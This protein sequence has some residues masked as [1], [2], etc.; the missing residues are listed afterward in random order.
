MSAP[1]A[2]TSLA[3]DETAVLHRLPNGKVSN[4]AA[5]SFTFTN[6]AG[7]AHRLQKSVNG[8]TTWTDAATTPVTAAGA[9]HVTATGLALSTAHLFRIRAENAEASTWS[10]T[11]STTTPALATVG[12]PPAMPTGFVAAGVTSYN[13]IFNWE[14]TSTNEA[15]FH[16]EV[17]RGSTVR[18]FY[19]P[20]LLE[21]YPADLSKAFTSFAVAG[22]IFSARLRALGGKAGASTLPVIASAWTESIIF[23]LSAPAIRILSPLTA[24]GEKGA[25]FSYTIATNTP[26]TDWTADPLP[27]GLTFSG[28][29]ISGTPTATGVFGIEIGA[30]DGAT[31]DHIVITVTIVASKVH[32][33]STAAATAPLGK[34]F[35]YTPVATPADVTFT[36]DNLPG[37]LK[38]ATVG[39]K[40]TLSG[41][42]DEPGQYE[43]QII[44]ASGT[45]SASQTLVITVPPVALLTS[46]SLKGALGQDYKVTIAASPSGCVFTGDD[47]PGWLSI[48]PEG[49]LSGT[50]PAMGIYTFDITA[51]LDDDGDSATFT[52]VVGP[53]FEVAAEV[54]GALGRHVLE[55]VRFAGFGVVTAWFLSNAPAGLELWNLVP[56]EGEPYYGAVTLDTQTRA[57]RGVPTQSGPFVATISVNV[58]T[59]GQYETF[60]VD[61]IFRITG[62]RYV[63]W[64]HADPTLYDLQVPIRGDAASRTVRSYYG[65]DAQRAST[66]SETVGDVTTTTQNPAVA[67]NLLTLKRG[68]T[69]PRIGILIR[70]DVAIL[71]AGVTAVRL[72]IRE[73][74]AEDADYLFD[75]EAVAT[76]VGTHTYFLATFEVDGD[77][78]EDAMS[79][80]SLSILSAFGEISWTYEGALYTSPTFPITIAED[81][82]R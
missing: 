4:K 33:A 30:E 35:S 82:R 51:S 37:W 32:I 61:V 21:S 62:G 43:L 47:L 3:V 80:D 40:T 27:P 9:D 42:P 66:S 71:G 24:R 64:F 13:V 74:E 1:S 36:A 7:T 45:S 69:S 63:A 59:G 23:Q 70:D 46:R 10:A 41:T 72:T 67:G 34:S 50:P 22:Q 31:E 6:V 44:A 78:L 14:D 60:S 65:I 39:T 81:V 75:V 55:H 19:V 77:A 11:A 20:G 57:I 29:V 16:I 49:V 54:E 28:N 38:L 73:P 52:L 17:S 56:V 2:P 79:D 15:Y 25:P 5:V 76:D 12:V 53:L 68:D 48:T 58:L 8:G 26:A 18:D